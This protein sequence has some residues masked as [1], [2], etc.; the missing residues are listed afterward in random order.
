MQ[1]AVGLLSKMYTKYQDV[2]VCI[3]ELKRKG[4]DRQQTIYA[5]MEVLKVNVVVADNWVLH[6]IAWQ[7]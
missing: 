2:E 6:S 4:F 7:Y 1:E 3:A 5:L